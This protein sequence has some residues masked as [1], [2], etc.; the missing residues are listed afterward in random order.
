MGQI[1]GLKAVT[2]F[3]DGSILTGLSGIF[4]I[5]VFVIVGNYLISLSGTERGK[6]SKIDRGI[7]ILK[8]VKL[9]FAGGIF[10]LKFGLEGI[11]GRLD[12]PALEIQLS[13]LLPRKQLLIQICQQSLS[14]TAGDRYF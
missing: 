6:A 10:Q 13:G 3:C 12:A 11:I 4:Q 8:N 14:F 7:K 2:Q 5:F 9:S 1:A